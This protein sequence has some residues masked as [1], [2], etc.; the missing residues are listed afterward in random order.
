MQKV[1]NGK[2]VCVNYKG[3]L[4]S[5][6]VFDETQNDEPMEWQVGSG[7]VIKGFEDSV[8]GMS[9]NEKKMFTIAPEDAYGIRDEGNIHTFS[10][11]EVPEDM[12]PQEGDIISIQMQDGEQIPAQITQADHEKVVVDLNHPLAGLPLTFEVEVVGIS[13]TPTQPQESCGS[14]CG[15]DCSS[16]CH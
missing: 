1:E 8:V 9:L 12:N 5:G 16:G 15:C 3:T 14:G 11:K 10:R 2:F 4:D 7:D 6:D 13:D